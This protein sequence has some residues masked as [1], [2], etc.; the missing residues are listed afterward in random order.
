MLVIVD[1]LTAD[2]AQSGRLAE[3]IATAFDEGEGIALALRDD[4]R[5]RFTEFPACSVCDTPGALITPALFSFNNPR[6]ACPVCNGFGATLEYDLSLIVP[7]PDRS[8]SDGAIDPWTK[9]R[10]EARRRLLV[11]TAKKLGAD[12]DAPWST[13]PDD[14]REMLLRGKLGRFIGIFP[15]LHELEAKRYKQYIRVFLRQYQLAHECRACHGARLAT[16]GPRDPDR[17][18]VDR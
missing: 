15:F 3:A 9:P 2:A 18:Q 1:R 10:Y 7:D 17:R 8:L 5:A 6:G 4:G 16:R 14:T 12:P 13:L 11:A